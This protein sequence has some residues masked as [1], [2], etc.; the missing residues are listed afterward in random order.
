[1]AETKDLALEANQGDI[2]IYQTEAGGTQ[3]DVRFVEET[4]WLTQQQMAEL[5]QTSRSNI[6]EHIRHIYEE[7]E[8]EEASTCRNFRQVRTEGG[9]QVSR[10]IAY[11][12]L[13]MIISLG[14]RVKSRIATRFRRWASE[15]LKEYMV[16]GF[17]IRVEF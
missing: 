16:K 10:E 1:M 14:Y 2:V 9:R 3:I 15:R 7:G 8:L 17:T 5:F 4:V 13:D 11:Y 12:N 6:A